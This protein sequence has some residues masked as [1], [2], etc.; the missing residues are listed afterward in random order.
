MKMRPISN[1][2]P[3]KRSTI[4][5]KKTSGLEV[6]RSRQRSIIIALDWYDERI[7]RGIYKST[8]LLTVQPITQKMRLISSCLQL[9]LI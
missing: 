9:D 5:S 2:M 4:K 1:I 3:S 8:W 6:K 7:V